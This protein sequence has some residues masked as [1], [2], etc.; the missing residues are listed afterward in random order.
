MASSSQGAATVAVLDFV[1]SSGGGRIVEE[2]TI[3]VSSTA[4][5]LPVVGVLP[6]SKDSAGS[7]V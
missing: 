4:A 3:L 7:V 6:F 5:V 2:A 1:N